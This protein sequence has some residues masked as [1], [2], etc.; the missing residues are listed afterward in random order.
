MNLLWV[1]T[2]IDAEFKDRLVEMLG[3]PE[4][5]PPQMPLEEFVEETMK[6]LDSLGDD[7]KP[8][9]EFSVGQ[10]PAMVVD[11]W[12][13]AFGPFLEQFHVDG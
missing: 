12:R 6:Q 4:K 8:R 5:C 9:K 1:K 2:N 10:L 11:T 13:K 7:G 3:G